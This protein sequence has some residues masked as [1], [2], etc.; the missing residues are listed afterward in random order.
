MCNMCVIPCCFTS[1]N[2]VRIQGTGSASREKGQHGQDEPA[3]PQQCSKDES[4]VQVYGL[5]KRR[6]GWAP[7]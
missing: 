5:E 1:I 3:G 6:T 2:V 7:E 4:K